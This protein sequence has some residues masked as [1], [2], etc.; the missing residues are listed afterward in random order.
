MWQTKKS[1]M[2]RNLIVGSLHMVFPISL[3]K[4]KTNQEKLLK[5]KKQ[6]RNL[7]QNF[8]RYYT[9]ITKLSQNKN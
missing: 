9:V 5:L 4:I 8:Y 2:N 7:V 6:N 1:K 3:Q